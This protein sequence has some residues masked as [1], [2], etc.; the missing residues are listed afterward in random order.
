MSKVRFREVF[1]VSVLVGL[2]F[3]LP[4]ASVAAPVVKIGNILPLS[5]PSATVGIQNKNVQDMAAAEIN[6]AGGIKSLGGAKIEM[7]YTDSKSDPTVGVTEAERLINT[8][9]VHLL[10]GCWNSAVTYPTT[11]VAEK[12]GIPFMVPVSVA[13]KITERG[14]KYT[15]RIAA[16]AGWTVRDQYRF[17]KDVQDEFKTKFTTIAFVYENGDWG[18]GNADSWKKLAPEYGYKIV[19]DEPYPSTSTDMAPVVMKIKKA[20]PDVVLFTS[21]AADAI[22]LTNT[23]AELKV[24]PKAVVSSAGGHADPKYLENVEKNGEYFFDLNEWAPDL[25]KPGAKETNA[26]FKKLY[27]VDLTG[28]TADGYAA[29]YVIKDA[30]ERAASLDPKKIRD[31]LAATNLKSGPA[32]I[33][34]FNAV[35]F[36]ESGQ[37]KHAGLIIC[38]VREMKGQME[39]VTVWPKTVRREGYKLVF[40]YPPLGK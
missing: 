23:M 9:K 36:D 34:S 27:G 31:A 18:T 5:G 10:T 40:P 22:L 29:M 39:L 20:N 21:N 6:E 16:K 30:L 4:S 15:F 1:W 32:M 35:A 24:R 7:I 25:K 8:E 38:Q 2:F 28:E 14:F 11:Q 17:L 19:L 12:Y 13:D 26:K 37:N 33:H 3:I